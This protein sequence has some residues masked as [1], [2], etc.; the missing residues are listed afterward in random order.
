MLA[1]GGKGIAE[2]A[3]TDPLIVAEEGGPSE[4]CNSKDVRQPT[5]RRTVE[6]GGAER[7]Q[8]NPSRAERKRAGGERGQQPRV[9]PSHSR[10]R[11]HTPPAA[12]AAC[13]AAAAGAVPPRGVVVGRHRQQLNGPMHAPG[14]P[15]PSRQVA[16][17]EG[18]TDEQVA[19][20]RQE[21][22]ENALPEKGKSKLV[23][24]LTLALALALTLSH[25]PTPT[26]PS[27]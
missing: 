21:W 12:H 18:L 8:P 16:E 1:A 23:L 15:L 10:A 13:D 26:S 17:H 2:K 19:E 14:S 11:L 3:L 20:L 7:G 27:H 22:G 25:R 24:L 4:V 5:V 9:K 6:P